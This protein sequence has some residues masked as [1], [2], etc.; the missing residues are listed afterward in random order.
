MGAPGAVIDVGINRLTTAALTGD[1]QFDA[2][3]D[4][5]SWITRCRAGG[6]D[7]RGH[8]MQ[9]TLDAAELADGQPER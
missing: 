7:D 6:A 9:N 3:A 8:L 2:A 5:A 1:V 4:R